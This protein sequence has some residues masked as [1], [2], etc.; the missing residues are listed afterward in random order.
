MRR[1]HALPDY[2]PT[3]EQQDAIDAFRTG[4]TVVIKAGAGTGKTTTLSM[5]ARTSD[6]TGTYLAFNKAIA[7]DAGQAMPMT[8]KARTVHS[9]AASAVSRMRGGSTLLDRLNGYRIDPWR[10]AR[11]MGLG[12][13]LVSVDIGGRRKEKVLQPGYLAGHVMRATA[14]FCQSAD[15]EP[16]VQHFPLIDGIDSIDENG[17]IDP[18][19]N[20]AVAREL[21]GALQDAWADLTNPAGD[22]RF[23]HDVYLKLAQL[24]GVEMPGR[25]LLYD[26]AQDANPVILAWLDAQRQKHGKQVVYVGD[27]FQQIYDWRG[28]V[29]ALDRIA[30]TGAEV[31]YLTQ[32]W[33][34]GQRIADAANLVL[35]QLGAEF[36]LTGNPAMDSRLAVSPG[37]PTPRAVLCRTNA[38]AVE[39]VLNLQSKGLQPHLVGGADEIVSFA[40]GAAKLQSGEKSSHYELACFESWNEVL[41]YVANDPQ[42]DELRMMV[43]LLEEYGIQIVL[44]ALDGLIAE[45]EADVIVSTAHKAKGRE[46]PIVRLAGDFGNDEEGS[47]SAM[48]PPELRLLYV[49]ATRARDVLDLSRCRPLLDLICPPNDLTESG[50]ATLWANS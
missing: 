6:W 15:D 19:N 4:R 34:F 5:C 25:F 1:R 2:P 45:A 21:L 41:D 12:P 7:M 3:P 11:K 16:G 20:R 30:E 17:R 40:H 29:D 32:S 42:G 50:L 18:R 46:W 28:A 37:G 33:R 39:T 44:D 38:A 8:V 43:N 10:L 14:R 24:E 22:L 48:A 47:A 35:A 26:E 27:G 31:T 23:S 9:I 13:L 36:Q 49:A